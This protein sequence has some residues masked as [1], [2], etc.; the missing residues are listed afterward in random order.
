MA[1]ITTPNHRPQMAT[2]RPKSKRPLPRDPA[3]QGQLIEESFDEDQFASRVVRLAFEPDATSEG[4]VQ[5]SDIVVAGGRGFKNAR[6]FTEAFKVAKR[7]GGAVG[8]SRAVVDQGW[9]SYAHQ[10]GLSGKS[11]TPRLYMALGISGSPNHL[12]GM[13]SSEVIVAVNKDPEANI[14]KVADFG[15][16]GDLAEV[17]PVLLERLDRINA[18]P[19]KEILPE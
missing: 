18:V 3:R 13:S 12:A 11:V 17:I 10:I 6:G 16:V 9:A 7:L 2:V 5:D 19:P 15:I 1:T 8:A 4:S 14:F